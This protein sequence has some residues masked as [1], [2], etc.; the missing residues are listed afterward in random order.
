MEAMILI[1]HRTAAS[2]S[3]ISCEKI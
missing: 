1:S 2:H 3:S